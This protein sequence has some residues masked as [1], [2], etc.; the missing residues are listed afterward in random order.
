MKIFLTGGTGFVGTNLVNFL[1][2]KNYHILI[3]SRKKKISKKKSKFIKGD[4]KLSHKNFNIIKNFSPNIVINLAWED[5]PNYDN[6]TLNKNYSK[7]KYFLNQI[8]KIKSINKI[9]MTG[10]CLEYEKMEKPHT[11]RKKFKPRS[12]FP[13]IKIKLRNYF[14]KTF[15]KINVLWPIIFYVYGSGQRKS[16]LI[17]SL[18][19][20]IRNDQKFIIKNYLQ[21]NDYIHID[22]VIKALYIMMI[23]NKKISGVFNVGSGNLTSN[24]KIFNLI[25]KK[26]NKN[27]NK[28][29]YNMSK[30]EPGLSADLKKIKKIFNW[31]PKISIEN[32]IKNLWI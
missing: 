10:T 18:I 7:Q 6:L 14:F 26:F 24:K 25:K 23:S 32:A 28:L 31:K 30:E 5:I 8:K 22:D 2:K 13:K 3:L 1:R 9:I 27:Y 29:E 20:S 17:P 11:E 16:S 12:N 15:D 4:L 19:K 21:E